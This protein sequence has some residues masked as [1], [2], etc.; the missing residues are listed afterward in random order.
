MLKKHGKYYADW[1]DQKGVRH[2]KA[3][4]TKKAAK[5]FVDGVRRVEVHPTPK[6]QP[7]PVSLAK[8]A[9]SGSPRRATIRTQ[10]PRSKASSRR[11]RTL[12]RAA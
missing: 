1:R 5:L 10:K 3:F 8:R 7:R 12:K 2:R 6:T 9:R 11:Q 4:S